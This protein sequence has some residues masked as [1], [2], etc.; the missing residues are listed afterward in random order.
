VKVGRCSD[1][2]PKATKILSMYQPESRKV[3]VVGGKIS[4]DALTDL[5]DCKFRFPARSMLLKS[6]RYVLVLV[7]DVQTSHAAA[8]NS[9]DASRRTETGLHNQPAERYLSISL[10]GAPRA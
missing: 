5:T 10:A 4:R 6:A 8:S 7:R 1:G 3:E 9:S 2:P